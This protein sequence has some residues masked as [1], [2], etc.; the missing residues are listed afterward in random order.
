MA[1]S[2]CDPCCNPTELSRSTEMYRSANLQILCQIRDALIA[3]EIDEEVGNVSQ[4]VS[5]TAET[6]I[7]AAGGVGVFLDMRRLVVRNVS[8]TPVTLSLRDTTGGPVID[9]FNVPAGQQLTN[10]G[11]IPQ[12][13][14]NSNWTLQSSASVDRIL[15]YIGVEVRT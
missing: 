4:I 5:S 7:M 1:R 15:I 3:S 13:T 8:A 6:T 10:L 11:P 2:S 14:A 12:T 9:T